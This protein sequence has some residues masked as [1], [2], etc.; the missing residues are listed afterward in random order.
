VKV[1]GDGE[2]LEGIAFNVDDDG[3]LILKL[4]DG[5]TRRVFAG[6]LSIKLKH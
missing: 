2:R 1:H 6:D 3:A 4:K 5:S